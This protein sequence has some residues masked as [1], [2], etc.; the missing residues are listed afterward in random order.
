MSP[1]GEQASAA[2]RTLPPALHAANEGLAF[3]LELLMLAGLAWWGSQAV[4]GAAGRLALA[5]AVPALTVIIWGL[6]A[7]PRARFQLPIV[8]VL[9]VKAIVFGGVTFAVFSIGHHAVAIAF[10]VVA[11]ANATAAAIDR[12]ALARRGG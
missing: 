6:F 3:L 11:A 4:S 2:G 7:A 5:I 12:D 1:D 10:A 9:A 8:G